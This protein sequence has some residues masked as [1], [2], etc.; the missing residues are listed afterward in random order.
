MH[1]VSDSLIAFKKVV[2][3]H[4]EQH[5]SD[6]L[7][8][9]FRKQGAALSNRYM[10]LREAIVHSIEFAEWA[11]DHV[12]ES[13]LSLRDWLDF[14]ADG[15]EVVGEIGGRNVFFNRSA[16]CYA[17]ADANAAGSILELWLTS[18]HYPPGW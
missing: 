8:S 15:V 1:N 9:L 4:A 12:C 3:A 16:G 6:Y 2:T 13:S 5:T 11:D 7:R 10:S 17:W 18:P 14:G